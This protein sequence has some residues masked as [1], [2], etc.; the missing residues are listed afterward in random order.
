MKLVDQPNLAP[1][2][3]SEFIIVLGIYI[4]PVQVY[5][6][7]CRHIYTTNYMKQCGFAGAGRTDN[8]G[9]FPLFNRQRN[10]I[11]CFNL[12]FTLAVDFA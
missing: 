2:E 4:L 8:R 6:A 5:L 11:K 12:V 7:T 1:A 9:E 3:N 10:I